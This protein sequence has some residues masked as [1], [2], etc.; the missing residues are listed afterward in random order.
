M[1][2]ILILL[3]SLLAFSCNDNSLIE[4]LQNIKNIGDSNP[5]KAIEMLNSVKNEIIQANEYTRM[6]AALLEMRLYD[7]AYIDATSDS[8]VKVITPYFEQNG[9]GSDLQETYYYAGSTYRDLK[10]TPRAL[11]YFLKSKDIAT[12]NKDCDSTLLRNTFSNLSVLYFSVQ[13]YNNALNMALKEYR[14]SA[15]INKVCINNLIHVADAY[16]RIDSIDKASFYYSKAEEYIDSSSPEDLFL[17]LYTFSFL[18]KE[19]R[20]D[21]YHQLIKDSAIAPKAFDYMAIAEYHLLKNNIDSAIICYRR[22]LDSENDAFKK[23][24]AAKSL[25]NLYLNKGDIRESNQYAIQYI[26]ISESLDLGKRQELASTVN[27]Q[28]QYYKDSEKE[29][30]IIEDNYNYRILIVT[31]TSIFIVIILLILANSNRRKNGYLREILELSENVSDLQIE[32][33]KMKANAAKVLQEHED[34]KKQYEQIV[35]NL[36]DERNY[37]EKEMKKAE[38]MLQQK[39]EAY[40]NVLSMLH[41]SNLDENTTG[42]IT[43]LRK[44]SEGKHKMTQ[45]EWNCFYH[46]IDTQHPEF[47]E[48]ITS[49][50]NSFSEAEQQ[51]FYLLYAGFTN[52]QIENITGISHATTWRWVKKF[53]WVKN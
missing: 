45:E 36:N 15:E 7:K 16:L 1:K 39:Q 28:Y 2:K 30:Q 3:F 32:K 41:Q 27:N 48:R 12:K 31:A 20:A 17:M 13:D 35:E 25:A 51:V 23:Y 52:T 22:L 4:K 26:A 10:D 53:S 19:N 6:K 49:H 44:A 43:K 33:D 21:Y 40:K 34:S 5:S 38:E 14:I 47:I 11:D 8:M 18:K 42:I 29:K 46:A 50:L 9:C 37:Y 24:D